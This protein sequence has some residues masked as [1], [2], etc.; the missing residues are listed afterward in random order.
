MGG[1]YQLR[2]LPLL[3][4]GLGSLVGGPVRSVVDGGNLLPTG[5]DSVEDVRQTEA[6]VDRH[7][8]EVDVSRQGGGLA[9]RRYGAAGEGEE[10]QPLPTVL[11]VADVL[12]VRA[13]VD[14]L[15]GRID[16]GGAVTA[17]MP[18]RVPRQRY[19]AG[20]VQRGDARASHGARVGIVTPPVVVHPPLVTADVDRGLRDRDRQQGVTAGPGDPRRVEVAAGGCGLPA[21]RG[22]AQGVAD[23]PAGGGDDEEAAVGRV[24]DVTH[25]T[26]VGVA[27][28]RRLVVVGVPVTDLLPGARPGRA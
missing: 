11:A 10:R 5:V 9:P 18:A 15:R 17:W 19:P 13:D 24:C 1:V 20:R 14:A 3:R 16:H 26:V 23:R 25:P 27:Q 7:V 4:S 6:H 12:G 8:G 2:E 21:G 28:A 22:V